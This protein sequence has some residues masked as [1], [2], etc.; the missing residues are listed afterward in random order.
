MVLLGFLAAVAL[1]LILLVLVCK[2]CCLHR[3]P[4][5]VRN[6]I[7]RLKNMLLYN[8]L[9][10]YWMMVFLSFSLGC[11]MQIE[12][13]TRDATLWNKVQSVI[14]LIILIGF[15]LLTYIVTRHLFKIIKRLKDLSFRQ[16]YGTLYVPCDVEKGRKAVIFVA[17]FCLRRF[18]VAI[19]VAFLVNHPLA[20]ILLTI[21]ASSLV[22]LWH[23]KVNPMESFHQ[24]L[25]Y[26]GNEYLYLACSFYIMGFSQYNFSPEVRY[27]N[28]WIYLVFVGGILI[29][30]VVLM[31]YEIIKGIIL[32]CKRRKIK[33]HIKK[34]MEERQ[35]L[36]LKNG[37]LNL[38]AVPQEDVSMQKV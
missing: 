12:L 21:T 33:N 25:L 6:L 7:L 37:T 22:F 1:F 32:Y 10:R 31:L 20:Q 3:C 35:K 4:S 5:V 9:L 36:A 27:R 2:N 38:Q 34:V 13:T 18:I 15:L 11:M 29:L 17:I 19:F 28:G 26:S 23:I 14:S 30:N 8:S 24:N 16:S